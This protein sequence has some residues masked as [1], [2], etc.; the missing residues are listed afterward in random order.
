MVSRGNLP[1]YE[2]ILLIA[3]DDEQGTTATGSMFANAMGGA[4]LAEL[5]LEGAARIGADKKK[6]V[7]PAI[8][9]RATDPILAEALALIMGAR[10]PK[11]ASD[12]VLKF[13]GLKDLKNRAARQLVAKGVLA[14]ETGTVLKIFK[15]TI[16][17]EADGGPERR[18]IARLEEAIFTATPDVDQRTVII[19]ALAQATSLLPNVIDKKRLK[20]R[21]E[22]LQKLTSGEVVGQATKE[23]VDAIHAAIMVATMVPI[24]AASTTASH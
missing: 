16:Y 6:Q 4:I 24:I 8:G 15:R 7:I 19:I 5:V 14:E 11:K 18:L 1:L 13:A 20:T 9:A 10:K 17:P 22:R 3:L 23:A 21:K 12:W 2:E